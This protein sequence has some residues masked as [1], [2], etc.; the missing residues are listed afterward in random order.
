MKIC[1]KRLA[2]FSGALMVIAMG[3]VGFGQNVQEGK[4]IIYFSSDTAG[5]ETY[6]ITATDDGYV[7]EAHG[8]MTRPVLV[9]TESMTIGW[10]KNFQ[11]QSFRYKGQVGPAEQEIVTEF[12]GEQAKSTVSY[13]GNKLNL[14]TRIHPDTVVAP[15]GVFAA[16][17]VLDRRYDFTKEDETQLVYWFGVPQQEVVATLD[18][19]GREELSLNKGTVTLDHVVLR[20]AHLEFDVFFDATKKLALLSNPMQGFEVYY[21]GYDKSAAEKTQKLKK[22]TEEE[23]VFGLAGWKLKGALTLPRER[24][25]KVPAVVLVHGSGPHDRDETIGPNQPFRDIAEYLS[26][27]GFAALRYD[28]RSYLY[29]AKLNARKD[30]LTLDMETIDDAVEGVKFLMAHDAI[31]KTKIFV[32]GHSLGGF[33]APWIAEKAPKLAGFIILAGFTRPVDELVLDQLDLERKT[34]ISKMS[35]EEIAQLKA[36]FKAIRDGSAPKDK[37]VFDTP[38]SYWRDLLRRDPVKAMASV[39]APGLILQGEKD[40]QVTMADFKR[41]QQWLTKSGRKDWEA[42]SF[43]GLNHL[44]IKV[45]GESNGKD[46]LARGH[47][48]AAVL[49]YMGRWLGRNASATH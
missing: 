11:P 46:S 22:F 29:G 6:K 27:Q 35:D 33:A 37:V 25:A 41:W 47:M 21:N 28:K 5:E 20:I 17:A 4:A 15:N 31:D 45:E 48:D 40:D 30:P 12:K 3:L 2:A 14:E 38:V 10:N 32:L 24:R 19:K 49:E 39:K 42:K 43:P 16:L 23:V 36:D 18:Y 9:V 13:P 26:S 44:F 8:K 34:G 1:V 7:M